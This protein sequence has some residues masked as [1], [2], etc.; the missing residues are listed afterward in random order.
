VGGGKG[1]QVAKS[2]TGCSSQVGHARSGP[3]RYVKSIMDAIQTA[4]NKGLTSEA[5]QGSEKASPAP[6]S[7][8]AWITLQDRYQNAN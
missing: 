3:N 5:V 8:K 2:R 7:L 4:V 1:L 6:R